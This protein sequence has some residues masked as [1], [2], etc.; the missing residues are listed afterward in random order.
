MTHDLFGRLKYRD[1]DEQW[2]GYAPLAGFAAHA[3]RAPDAPLTPDDAARMVADMS[4]AVENMRDLMRQQLGPAADAAFEQWDR[5]AAEAEARAAEPPDE[6][7]P[8]EAERDRRR[9]ARAERR[10]ARLARGEFPVGVGAAPGEPPGPAQ[11]AAYRFLRDHEAEVLGEVL[12]RVWE[13]FEAHYAD[14]RWRQV[15]GLK[16]A[17]SV[18]DLAG[19]FALTRLDV[20]RESRGGFA[21][22]VFHVDSEW[23]DEHG[24]LVVYSPDSRQSVWTSWDI[25]GDHLESDDPAAQP[26]EFVPTPHDELLEAILTGDE[27]KARALVAAGADVNALREDEYPPLWIAVDQVEPDEVRRLLAFGADPTLANPDEGTTP[28]KHAKKLYREL[29]FA[30]S[31][32]RD[33]LAE[34]VLSMVRAA[35]APQFEEVKSRLEEIM[36]LLEGHAR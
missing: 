34:G 13:S 30:P 23:Q 18:A 9:A 16:P 7:T 33:A 35:N 2:V 29:G 5:E 32:K 12:A 19:R 17:A 31:K 15:M 8:E 4:L 27:E 25:L 22:L 21:H 24:L 1:R 3:T 28:L 14:E 36:R 26:D 6:P 20:A 11:E 10:A